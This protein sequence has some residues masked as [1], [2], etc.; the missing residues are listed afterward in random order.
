[1]TRYAV[2]TRDELW[3]HGRL[4]E[5]R[6]SHGEATETDHGVVGTIV[7]TDTRDD[8]LVAQC[9]H[10]MA[11]LRRCIVPDARMRLV[12]EASTEGIAQTITVR[13][14]GHSIVTTPEHL[15]QDLAL[16][17]TAGVP[18]AGPAASRRL[19]ILW[20]NG[21][22]AVLLHEAY[23]HPLEHGHAP[24]TWPAWLHVEAPLK[25]RRASFRD[26]PLLRMT[27]LTARQAN[28]PFELPA[29]RIEVHLIDGGHYEPLTEVVTVR[30]AA[31]TI[32]GIPT[33]PFT[34]E[35]TRAGIARAIQGA[36]GDPIRYPGVICSREGQELVVGSRAP[37]LLT[38]FA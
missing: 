25:L 35:Q 10:L 6:L 12:A 3:S 13:H 21:T 33:G 19:P 28:A 14:H 22:A 37:E 2:A 23:G 8:A 5:R 24:L 1:L 31:A 17:R 26:V 32:D 34:L 20:K 36:H 16:L 4:L 27:T 15:E 7:A 38:V 30:V 18:P 9:D 11:E 29:E